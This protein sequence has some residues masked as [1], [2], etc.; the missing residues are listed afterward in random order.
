MVIDLWICI[1]KARSAIYLDEET[2]KMKSP[3]ERNPE[4]WNMVFA[5]GFVAA[6]QQ[7]REDNP[8]EKVD[9][10][11]QRVIGIIVGNI[12]D[13]AVKAAEQLPK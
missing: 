11:Q 7:F 1:N 13:A 5:A 6:W 3:K 12:A 9:E 10:E 8:K 2:M 4:L